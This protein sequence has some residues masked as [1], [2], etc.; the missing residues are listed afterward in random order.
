MLDEVLERLETTQLIDRIPQAGIFS[1]AP[2]WVKPESR[3]TKKP[4][5][6]SSGGNLSSS[7][8]VFVP[9]CGYESNTGYAKGAAIANG[10]YF[11]S[12]YSA[13]EEG[14]ALDVIPAQFAQECPLV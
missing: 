8:L 10:T 2:F 6:I 7:K 1:S 14:R 9:E 11:N 3:C 12:A 13:R 5:C 4:L